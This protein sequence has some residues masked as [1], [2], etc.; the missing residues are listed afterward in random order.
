MNSDYI[1]A[2]TDYRQ[3]F[4]NLFGSGQQAPR[5]KECIFNPWETIGTATCLISDTINVSGILKRKKEHLAVKTN[6]EQA[7]SMVVL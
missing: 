4:V 6:E 3:V 1:L 2:L 7:V 5:R